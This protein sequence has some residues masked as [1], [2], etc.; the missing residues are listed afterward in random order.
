MKFYVSLGDC[1]ARGDFFPP[2]VQERLPD[3]GTFVFSEL[4][5][6]GMTKQQLIERIGD[7][8]VL[9]SAWDS[10][11]VDEDVL[12]AAPR[13]R[14]HA[15]LCGSVANYVSKEEYD[16]GILVL[17]GNDV[18]AQSVAEGC[19][20]YT[21][22]ALRR[23]EAYRESMRKDGWIPAEHRNRGLIGKKV[24][25]ISYGAIAAYYARMLRAFDVE[26]YIASRTVSDAELARIG[27]KRASAAQIFASCDVISLH[28][29]LNDE[30][31]G[32]ITRELLHS[33]RDGALFVN[34]AR[35]ALV[36]EQALCDELQTGR[37][38]AVLDVYHTEP[39][40][41]EHPLRQMPNVLLMPHVAGP[42]VDLR[43]EITLRLL[44]EIRGYGQGK[45]CR[46]A[47][48]YEYAMRMT[49]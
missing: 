12:R 49:R 22:N 46:S 39:L 2:R 5:A 36:D 21:L 42:T 37:F 8:E 10:P 29:A 24:G 19:L 43:Q 44:E 25:L 32:K 26:L 6:Q 27:A 35:G 18:F 40:P 45:P 11:R 3:Y 28:T 30:T 47:I 34:T 17:S 23:T 31:R 7:A 48:P 38:D 13:L 41:M 20:C 14:I 9:M 15:H 4:A 16:R 1:P 33:I